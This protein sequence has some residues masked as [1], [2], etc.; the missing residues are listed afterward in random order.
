RGSLGRNIL[1]RFR[2]TFALVPAWSPCVNLKT[3]FPCA[4]FFP[5]FFRLLRPWHLPR[6]LGCGRCRRLLPQTVLMPALLNRK[7]LLMRRPRPSVGNRMATIRQ[8]AKTGSAAD[9][10]LW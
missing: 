7:H 1:A 10:A 2:G 8:R 5:C 9:A 3:A 6:A 4:W